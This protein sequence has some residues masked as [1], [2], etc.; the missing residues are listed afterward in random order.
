MD[1]TFET[2]GGSNTGVR[3][4][5]SFARE[6]PR[7]MSFIRYFENT[8]GGP[9]CTMDSVGSQKLGIQ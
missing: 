5:K 7:G 2:V 4:F 9:G 6:V 1:S 3:E 8:A